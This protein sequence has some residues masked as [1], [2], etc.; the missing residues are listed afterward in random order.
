MA[1]QTKNSGLRRIWGIVLL[2]VCVFTFLSMFS[3]D[4]RDVGLLH[5]P[6]IDPPGNLIGPVGAYLAFVFFM[7]FGVAAYLLPIWCFV[8]GVILLFDDETRVWPRGL[9]SGVAA[10]CIVLLTALGDTVWIPACETLNITDPGGLF[11]RLVMQGLLVR[12]LSPVGGTILVASLLACSLVFLVE[13]RNLVRLYHGTGRFSIAAGHGIAARIAA[14]QERRGTEAPPVVTPPVR[15]PRPVRPLAPVTPPR[16]H[17]DDAEVDTDFPPPALRGG[18]AAADDDH[19]R[20]PQMDPDAAVDQAPAVE[21]AV[22]ESRPYEVP[23]I[24]LLNEEGD[25]TMV[26]ADVTSISS[27]LVS[28][29]EQFGIDVEVT[30]VERG[31]SVTRYELLPAPG[32][33][34]EK[35]SALR[36]NLTMALKAGDIRVQVPVPGKGVIGVEVPNTQTKTVCLREVLESSDLSWEKVKIPVVLGKDVG[37]VNL[38]ADLTEMPH[39]LVAGATGAGKTVCSNTILAGILMT[40]SPEQVRFMLIDPKRVEFTQYSHL[41][42]LVVPV[43]VESSKVP[44][45]LRWALNEME[46]RYKLFSDVGVRNIEAYNTREIVRQADLFGEEPEPDKNA[47]PPTLPYVVIVVDELSDLMMSKNKADIEDSICRLAQLSRA[48]GIHMIL[49]TQRPSVDV[50]TGTIKANFPARI[51]FQVAQKTDSRTI[52][53]AVGAEGLLGRGDMLFL[54]PGASRLVRAQGALTKDDEIARMVSFI[55]RQAEPDYEE[56]IR[57]ELETKASPDAMDMDGEDPEILERAVEVIRQQG[58]A[59]TSSLQ[60]R[61]RIGYTR[62]ARIMDVLEEQGIIGP[63]RGSEPREILVD[64]DGEIPD[65]PIQPDGEIED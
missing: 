29:L 42:H 18:G 7:T 3:Y 1:S 26:A 61:M 16:S 2:P 31:P 47:P 6:P 55:R 38:L 37:G 25:G 4:W 17:G 28:T 56:D 23:P 36:N 54:P 50:I 20:E 35:I 27:V 19:P 59:S 8:F 40:R 51:A 21:L 64:L 11:G 41:P 13:V 65:N 49:S 10:L 32:V 14:W 22:G 39:L 62:A 45:G 57:Q 15:P 46:R 52:L 58:R 63:P 48:V 60:R 9:W 12:W 44:I 30:H 24:S 34:V 53:D 5:A 33:R 43:I